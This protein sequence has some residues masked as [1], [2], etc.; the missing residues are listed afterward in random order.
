MVLPGHEERNPADDPK[1][2]MSREDL[3]RS[4]PATRGEIEKSMQGKLSAIR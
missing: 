1:F 2:D 3:I 4:H